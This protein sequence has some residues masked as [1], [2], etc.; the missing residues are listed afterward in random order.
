MDIINLLISLIS[1]AVGG[2]VTGAAMKE[3]S[4]STLGNSI[5]GLVGGGLGTFILHALNILNTSGL[6]DQGIGAIAANIGASGIS[7]AIL[8]FVVT[9]IKNAMNKSMK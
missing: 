5:S 1:G 2:N 6:M 3:N 9:L 8:T 4:L 7:G